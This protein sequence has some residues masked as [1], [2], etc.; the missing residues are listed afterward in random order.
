MSKRNLLMGVGLVAL[1][2]GALLIPAGASGVFGGDEY[3]GTAT[4]VTPAEGAFV[5]C[6]GSPFS[7]TINVALETSNNEDKDLG[8]AASVLVTWMIEGGAT[9]TTTSFAADGN[10]DLS[11][12]ALPC[13]ASLGGKTKTDVVFQ[14]KTGAGGTGTNTGQSRTRNVDYTRAATSSG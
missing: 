7:A 1:L 8:S 6:S 11:S 13:P 10:T 4:K 3:T 14:P 12:S 2:A 9:L 5:V